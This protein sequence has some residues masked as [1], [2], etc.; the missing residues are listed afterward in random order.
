VP[1]PMGGGGTPPNGG[2]TACPAI[3]CDPACPNGVKMDAN[4]CPTCQCA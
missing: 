3:G 1:P 2:G 4:G